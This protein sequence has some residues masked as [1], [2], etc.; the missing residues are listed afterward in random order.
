MTDINAGA[1]DTE[2][3]EMGV[4]DHVLESISGCQ[5]RSL[6]STKKVQAPSQE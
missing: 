5:R 1:L 4:A 6:E 3:A 2:L